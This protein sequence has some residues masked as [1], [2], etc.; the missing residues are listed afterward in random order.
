[1]QNRLKLNGWKKS[2]QTLMIRKLDYLYESDLLNYGLRYC[3]IKSRVF[4]NDKKD[5]FMKRT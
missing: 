5:R 2:M 4:H 1:M 3:Q